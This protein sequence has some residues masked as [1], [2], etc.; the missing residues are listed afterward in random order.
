[1]RLKMSAKYE[2]IL[3]QIIKTDNGGEI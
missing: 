2:D 1:M 3:S